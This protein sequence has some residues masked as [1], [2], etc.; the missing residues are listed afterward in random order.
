MV[1]N[2]RMHGVLLGALERALRAPSVHNT[3]PWRWQLGDHSVELY[4]D[5]SRHLVDTDPDQRDLMISCGAVLHH[6][7]VAL[8]TAGVAST[9]EHLRDSPGSGPLAI[10]RIVPGKPDGRAV[11]LGIA[12]EARRTDRRAFTG[13][14]EPALLRELVTLAHDQG[15]RLHPIDDPHRRTRLLAIL[16]DA[17]VRQRHV[18][19]YPAE[20]AI[21]TR[22]DS[23]SRDGVP[24]DLRT[25]MLSAPGLRPFPPGRLPIGTRPRLAE[26]TDRGA[27]P[28]QQDTLAVLATDT[29]TPTERLRAGEALSAILLF[30]TTV[31]LG[32]TPLSQAMEIEHT[33]ARLARELPELIGQPQLVIRLGHAPASSDDLP[34]SPRRSLS[35]VLRQPPSS[36]GRPGPRV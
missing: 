16:T 12:I 35:W 9:L 33:R 11:T 15:A 29:D 21:W 28:V 20:L 2:D 22:R 24:A 27:Q 10:V 4:A 3:Q 30:A 14:V 23:R 1:Q 34:A 36:T 5:R 32:S 26:I 17:A 6:L 7:Q 25:P 13:P 19:G 31:G 18:P 8:A